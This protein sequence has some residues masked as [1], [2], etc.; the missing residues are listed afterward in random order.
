M[1]ADPPRLAGTPRPQ[2]QE[3]RAIL[4]GVGQLAGYVLPLQLPDGSLPDVALV[5]PRSLAVFIADAKHTEGPGDH[6]SLD[7]LRRYA[8]WLSR[9]RYGQA[10]DVLAVAHPPEHGDG[11][12]SALTALAADA[13]VLT[14]Y[15]SVRWIGCATVVS[16][17]PCYGRPGSTS[18]QLPG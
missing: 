5:A 17:L 16:W 18:Q 12:L 11:W 14:G 13:G 8:A 1:Q 3:R 7:R 9:D 6:A 10:S 2:H 4:A 15:G